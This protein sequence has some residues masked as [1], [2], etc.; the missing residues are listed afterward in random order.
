LPDPTNPPILWWIR[1]DQDDLDV[2][3]SDST[4]KE[5]GESNGG[6]EDT[7]LDDAEAKAIEVSEKAERFL[8]VK[9]IRN[10]LCGAVYNQ[11]DNSTAAQFITLPSLR[12][13]WTDQM[14][15]DF[16]AV[17][18]HDG[19]GN[20]VKTVQEDLIKTVSILVHMKWED[21]SRFESIFFP[22]GWEKL[23]CEDKTDKN[24]PHARATLSEHSFL[25][26]GSA[27][28]DF[29]NHQNKYL[30]MVIKQF[31]SAFVPKWQP[32]PFIKSEQRNIGSGGFGIVTREVIAHH[33][34]SGPAPDRSGHYVDFRVSVD[35]LFGSS[36][37]NS[38]S[39]PISSSLVNVSRPDVILEK[40]RKT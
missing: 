8:K 5:I 18:G 27:A 20:P 40:R 34:F 33:Q 30:P 26:D 25:Q 14:L 39:R 10:R 12:T 3:N 13:I 2:M 4:S 16:L 29:L 17:L 35:L 36:I 1:T 11:D 22:D 15:K 32:L 19:R 31:E 23:A 7:K 37:S 24:L 28:T 6:L 38:V 21:W 9:K